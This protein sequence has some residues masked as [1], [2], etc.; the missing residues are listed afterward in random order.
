VTAGL[1]LHLG[2]LHRAVEAEREHA[3]GLGVRLHEIELAHRD[4]RARLHEINSTVAGIASAQNLISGR[5]ADEGTKALATMMSAEVQRLQRLVADRLPHRRRTVDLDDIV[6]QIVLSHLARGRV[7]VWEPSGLRALGRAD[8]I[9]EVV[10]VLLENAAVHGG[11]DAV[12]VQVT[13][14]LDGP[15]VLIA[16]TDQGQGVAPELRDR[17]FDWGVSRAGSPGQGIG[18]HAAADIARQ[19]G[20]R[21]E[22]TTTTTGACFQLHLTSAEQG[23]PADGSVAR[24][25]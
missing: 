20:G 24:A 18:L 11:P 9:A 7:V 5:P 8:D 12:T 16:V 21:L 23:V 15:G 17:I 13:R 14:E 4:D 1:L 10:N 2:R 19:L 3:A 6:G 22:L 25:S